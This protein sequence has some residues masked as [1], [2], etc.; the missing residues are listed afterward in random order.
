MF[1]LYTPPPNHL[2]ISPN[3]KFQEIALADCRPSYVTLSNWWVRTILCRVCA[4]CT[5][6]CSIGGFVPYCAECVHYVRDIAVLMGAYYTVQ[7]VCVCAF[8]HGIQNLPQLI[9]MIVFIHDARSHTTHIL[10]SYSFIHS[11]IHSYIRFI[12]H[13]LIYIFINS[14]IHLF[15][16]VYL[17]S[18]I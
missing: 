1:T 14:L 5:R 6:H 3:F 11:F 13:S 16:Y 10:S 15:I 18:F 7:S 8:I 2:S 4:L 9:S 17:H 12:I